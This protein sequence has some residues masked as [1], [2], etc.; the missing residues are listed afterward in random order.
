MIAR[1]VRD[2][3]AVEVVPLR[4]AGTSSTFSGRLT[5]KMAGPFELE[6][7]AADPINANF[8]VIRRKLNVAP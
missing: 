6:V 2:G 5:F 3:K 7:I 1:L 8:G 4:Y